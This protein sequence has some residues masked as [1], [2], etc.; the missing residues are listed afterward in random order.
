[1]ALTTRWPGARGV[2]F[3][4]GIRSS[5]R[6]TGHPGTDAGLSR[7]PPDTGEEDNYL[8][9]INYTPQAA[10]QQVQGGRRGDVVCRV[11]GIAFPVVVGAKGL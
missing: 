2:E 11:K 4:D 10:R 7:A 1:M 5:R 6:W 8:Q 9:V 3:G